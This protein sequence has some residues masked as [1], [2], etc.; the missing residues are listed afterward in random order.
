MKEDDDDSKQDIW[1]SL[2]YGES[3]RVFYFIF[4]SSEAISVHSKQ[5]KKRDFYEETNGAEKKKI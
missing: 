5:K 4:F 3:K 2:L 1:I